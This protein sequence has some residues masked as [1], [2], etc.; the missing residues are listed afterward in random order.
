M[1]FRIISMVFSV[2]IVVMAG[3]ICGRPNRPDMSTANRMNMLPDVQS[4][5]ASLMSW[6]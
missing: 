3:F 4:K 1:L 5:I 6:M 2:F